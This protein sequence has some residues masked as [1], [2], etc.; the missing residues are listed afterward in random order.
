MGKLKKVSIRGR[1]AFAIHCLKG[2]PELNEMNETMKSLILNRAWAFVEGKDLLD[3]YE[4]FLDVTPECILDPKVNISELDTIDEETYY[5][6]NFLFKTLPHDLNVILDKIS[7]IMCSNLYSSVGSYSAITLQYL[8]D[9]IFLMRK[10]QWA[11][12][13]IMP[14]LE[15]KFEDARGWGFPMNRSKFST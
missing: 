5:K 2:I 4:N 3:S 11:L 7:Y 1:V 12:P 13:E 15:S 10:N 6:L 9:I 14:F 8:S